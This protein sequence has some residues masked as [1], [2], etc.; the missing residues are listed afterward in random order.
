MTHCKYD[1]VIIGGGLMGGATAYH[2]I[3][4]DQ[5][6]SVAVVEMDPTY[7]KASSALSLANV[8][9]NFSLKQNIQISQYAMEVINTFQED[10]Q[11]NGDQPFISWR[12]QGN[13]FLYDN[14]GARAAKSS[15][16]LQ[17]SLDCAVDWLSPDQITQQYPLYNL[18]G[19]VAGTFGHNDGYLDGYCFLSAYK[20]KSRSLGVKYIN[21]EVTAVLSSA[22][23]VQGVKLST[24]QSLLTDIVVN[25][26]GAWAAKIAATADVNLPIAPT[27]RQVFC[28]DTTVKSDGPLPLTVW[29]SGIIFRTETGNH[30]ILVGDSPD[31]GPV[32]FDFS[33]DENYFIETLWPQL[34]EVVPAWE[35]LKLMKCYAGL[36]AIN[37]FD[38]NALLGEWPELKGFYLA[39][40]FSGHGLQQAPAVGRYISELIL[41]QTP[42]LDLSIFNPIRLFENKPI[43]ELACL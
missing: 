6:L 22:G 14:Q 33:C 13:L 17:K 42:T 32:G 23:K 18:N 39:N 21:A 9:T 15:H 2:L 35:A 27:N 3:K 1:V 37:T 29:P 5:S 10:M 12:R 28:L 43:T 41:N 25:C 19:I 38:W 16:Q 4:Q 20:S 24:G 26:A 31:V 36:Y 34:A 7:E 11:V 30:I 40:G 8:R